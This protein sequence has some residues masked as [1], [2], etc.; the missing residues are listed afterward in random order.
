M[1]MHAYTYHD[2]GDIGDI[3]DEVLEIQE[4]D[5]GNLNAKANQRLYSVI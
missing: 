3:S 4:M 2:Y 1:I 5:L